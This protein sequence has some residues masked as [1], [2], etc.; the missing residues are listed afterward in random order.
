M[1]L[2]IDKNSPELRS[3]FVIYDKHANKFENLSRFMCIDL[4][5][6]RGL[7]VQ[8]VLSHIHSDHI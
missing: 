1:L 5:I 6:A 8:C 4:I 2:V 7:D 3:V